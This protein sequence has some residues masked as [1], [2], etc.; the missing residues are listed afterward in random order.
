ME[1]GYV[2]SLNNIQH[3]NQDI[4]FGLRKPAG[5]ENPID[6]L[7]QKV[8]D[9]K[10]K[11][12]NRT[13]FAV[14]GTVLGLS[15][16]VAILNPRMSSTLID[17]LRTLQYRAGRQVEKNKGDFVKTKFY[18]FVSGAIRWCSR[19]L[20]YLNNVNSV[21]D[22]YY[23]Q[24]CTEEKSFIGIHN[25]DRRKRFAKIDKAFRKVMKKPHEFITECGDK[26]AKHTVRGSYKTA[27][28]KMDSLESL[29]TEYSKK[30]PAEE[31][32]SVI[33]NLAQITKE[34]E[35]FSG[36][37]LDKRFAGQEELMKDLDKNIRTRWQD[38]K[39][40]FT[41]KYVKNTEHIDQYLSFWAEDIM[42]PERDKLSEAGTTAVDRLFGN[43]EGLS[44]GY[45][46]LVS[47]IAQNLSSEEKS[48]LDKAV[49]K[50]E[51]SLRKANKKECIEYFDKKRDLV[52][53]S[54]PT[55]ILSSV[56]LLT[57]GGLTI[58]TSDDKDKRISR[59][60]TGI[61]PTVAG[62]GTNIAL[63]TMLYSGT[64]GLL[65]G[66]L[67]AGVLSLTGSMI[68]KARLKAKNKSPEE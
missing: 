44:G 16:L 59:L 37:N 49:N 57:I 40:G 1:F 67:T 54:A 12:H 27:A 45:R 17:K 5:T 21:K 11:K 66:V 52:L 3:A 42:K 23:K 48:T 55:D 60:I 13:A 14:G 19:F 20:S 58:A 41:N 36:A 64:K 68:D 2:N 4:S 47:K 25:P 28:Q 22:T 56:I 18:K 10:K 62:V 39:H 31:R 29:I 24:L 6:K 50:A 7:A 15:I 8:E 38:Y 51:K 63:T 32:K 53:G 33:E 61:I 65:Y 35:F 30:L 26:L 34:R 43:K 9:E 46:E